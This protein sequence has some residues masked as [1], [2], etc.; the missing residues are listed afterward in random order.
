M[1]II[2]IVSKKENN[3]PLRKEELDFAFN[4]YLNKSISD[5]EMIPLLKAICDNGMTDEETFLLTELFI[6]SGEI[7]DLSD[8]PGVKV[9]KHSTGGIGDKI[10]LIVS[11]IVAS[12]GVLVPKMSG[13]GLGYTGGTID[14]LESIE[15]FRTE[16]TLEEFKKELKDIGFVISS[17]TGNLCPMDKAIYALRDI[18][19]TTESIPLIAVSIMS[20]KI[21]SG[22]DKILIDVKCGNGA[23][24]KTLEDAKRLSDLMEKIGRHYGKETVC[25]ISDMNVPLGHN[26]GNSL[27][28]MEAL[29]ILR[30]RKGNLYDL[31]VKIASKMLSM[32]KSI[33]MDEAK[34]EVEKALETGQALQKFLDFVKYQGGDINSLRVSGYP[35]DI[36]AE[37]NGTVTNINALEIGKLSC[38]VGAGRQEKD[39]AIDYGAGILLNKDIGDTVEKGDLLF[40]LFAPINFDLT[41]NI[42]DYYEIK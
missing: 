29:D 39:D 31:S 2:E 7:L 22:A 24:M 38:L 25:E 8:I 19:N 9:D 36:L 27:E 15:G 41:L 11:P 28:V 12:C 34:I 33:S 13:R 35:F 3:L 40:I 10:T 37:K 21:A 6:R 17:Q 4:G 26:I 18:S 5:E 23:F 32:G 20:K 16:L 14:K 1:N 30:G 42:D